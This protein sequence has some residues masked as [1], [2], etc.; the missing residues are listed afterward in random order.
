MHFVIIAF[1]VPLL[2]TCLVYSSPPTQSN[3]QPS[4]DIFDGP[5]VKREKHSHQEKDNDVIEYQ[6]KEEVTESFE[7][8]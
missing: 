5:K 4:C 1:E 2:F 7:S 6:T 3:E 8:T